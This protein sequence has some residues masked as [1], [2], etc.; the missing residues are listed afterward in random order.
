MEAAPVDAPMN[1]PEVAPAPAQP[2]EKPVAK[3][4]FNLEPT[5][6]QKAPVAPKTVAP[7]VQPKT[8][9]KSPKPTAP[10]PAEQTVVPKAAPAR[11]LEKQ[12]EQFFDKTKGQEDTGPTPEDE[13]FIDEGLDTGEDMGETTAPEA[14][15]AAPP[16]AP[17]IAP[18]NL[19]NEGLAPDTSKFVKPELQNDI[20]QAIGNLYQGKGLKPYDVLQSLGK[21]ANPKDVLY[22]M[23]DMVSK[24]Q[25]AKDSK[26]NFVPAGDA[27]AVEAAPKP[28]KTVEPLAEG[29]APKRGPGRPKKEKP[30]AQETAPEET[31]P[32]PE[33][34]PVET[35]PAIEPE[36]LGPAIEQAVKSL[37][38]GKGL[39]SKQIEN[40]IAKEYSVDPKD[41]GRKIRDMRAEGQIDSDGKGLITPKNKSM[42]PKSDAQPPELTNALV[43]FV[44]ENPGKEVSEV[45]K[46]IENDP[47]FAEIMN[48][49]KESGNTSASI[50]QALADLTNAGKLKRDNK[51]R[52]TVQ[53]YVQK[54]EKTGKIVVIND[55]LYPF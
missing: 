48:S 44:K 21:G 49:L 32:E 10:K 13:A 41:I 17:V 31:A 2:A 11:P 20:E 24:G 3:P 55:R 42:V 53:A 14:P 7:K 5:P 37:F 34:A 27:S 47:R 52:L 19:K 4:D 18:K 30:I 39:T 29:A 33:Q 9:P 51:N 23:N 22:T 12:M 45:Y 1:A 8:A 43:D 6:A 38:N 46:T 35:K 54:L 28:E 36:K 25:L 40:E 16:K 50:P 26:G 15:K